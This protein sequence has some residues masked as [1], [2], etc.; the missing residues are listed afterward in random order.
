MNTPKLSELQ[1]SLMSAFETRFGTINRGL[2]AVFRTLSQV[3]SGEIRLVY[4]YGGEIQ[5]N[6]FPDLAESE[7]NGGTLERFGRARLGR[8]PFPPSQGL[9]LVDVT[10]VSGGVI[11][12]GITFKAANGLNYSNENALTLTG[13]TGQITLRALTPGLT[14]QLKTGDKLNS[15]EPMLNVSSVVTVASELSTPLNAETIEDYRDKV[16]QSF[17]TESQGGAAGDYRLWSSDAQGVE[18]VYPFTGMPGE[19]NLFVEATE[20]DSTDGFGTPSQTILDAVKSVVELDPDDSKNINDRGRLPM[21]VFE[22]SYL[23]VTPVP[24]AVSVL[25]YTGN[26]SEAQTLLGVAIKDYLKTVRPY[27]AGADP[28]DLSMLSVQRLIG[29]VSDALP[30]AY[31]FTSL[32]VRINGS[33]I[34]IR[35][36]LNGDIPIPGTITVTA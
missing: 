27:V 5:R 15:T 25:G 11:R 32:E 19:I 10:G 16:L 13:T 9:Y 24:V 17:R 26:T 31:N 23:P 35:K 34:S 20:Q 18:E 3:V 21:G 29:V 30:V 2:K 14:A 1:A 22:I 28:V 7:L 33:L 12:A 4:L 6:V 36:F 8:D